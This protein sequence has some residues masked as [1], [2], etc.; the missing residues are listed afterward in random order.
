MEMSGSNLDA[1]KAYARAADLN[2][3]VAAESQRGDAILRTIAFDEWAAAAF[4][5]G[6]ALDSAR[7]RLTHALDI[8]KGY[9]SMAG[10]SEMQAKVAELEGLLRSNQK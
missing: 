3:Q 10:D 8:A 1:G 6:G 5:D 9:R 4:G 2:Q 7:D